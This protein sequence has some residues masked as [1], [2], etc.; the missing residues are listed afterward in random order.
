MSKRSLFFKMSTGLLFFYSLLV[1]VDVFAATVDVSG[2]GSALRDAVNAANPGDTVRV[3]DSMDYECFNLPKAL[4]IEA[5]SGQTPRVIAGSGAAT[6][7]GEAIRV[8]DDGRGATLKGLHLIR[9]ENT[10]TQPGNQVI[11]V[12]NHSSDVTFTM[13]DC[14][15]E[16]AVPG[17][18][19]DNRVSGF[20]DKVVFNRCTFRRSDSNGNPL[21]MLFDGGNNAT[22]NQCTFGPGSNG[23]SGVTAIPEANGTITFDNCLFTGLKGGGRGI[24]ATDRPQTYNINGCTF[25]TGVFAIFAGNGSSSPGTVFNIHNSIFGAMN[26]DWQIFAGDGDGITFNMT[27]T[28]FFANT[29]NNLS[30]LGNKS[31]TFNLKHCTFAQ[32]PGASPDPQQIWFFMEGANSTASN[33]SVQNCIVSN[34]AS[35]V[36]A[37]L[38]FNNP[39]NPLAIPP[40][41]TAGKTLWNV[42]GGN[43]SGVRPGDVVVG[44]GTDLF[45]DPLFAGDGYHLGAGSAALDAGVDVGVTTD[46]DGEA[47]PQGGSVPDMGADE[48]GLS[49]GCVIYVSGGGSALGDAV[50]DPGTGSNCVIII[51]DSLEYN[52][53]NLNKPITIQAAVGQTPTVIAGLGGATAGGEAIRVYDDGRGAT[54][55]GLH[56]I[57]NENTSTQPG[58]QVIAVFNHSSDVTFTMEDCIVEIAVP[59]E[60]V[61]NRVSGFG[62]KVVFNRCTFRRSDSNGNPLVM[63]FDGGNNAT[64]NNCTFGPGSNGASG[65]T[66]IPEANGTITFNDCLFTGLKGGGR[67]ITAT[68]RPQTYNINDCTFAPGVFALF[69]GN[70]ASSPGT[71]FNIQRTVFSANNTDWQIFAGDGSGITFNLTNNVFFVDS[72]PHV[73]F[74]GS[75]GQNWNVKHCTF[76]QAPGSSSPSSVVWFFLEG[77]DPSFSTIDVRNCVVSCPDAINGVSLFYNNPSQPLIQEPVVT[78]GTTL[79]ETYNVDPAKVLS[80]DLIVGVGTNIFGH[81]FLDTDGYHL[82]AG[83]EALA[84]GENVGVTQDIDGESRPLGGGSPDLGADESAIP[85]GAAPTVTPTPENNPTPT[86]TPT[87][88]PTQTPVPS[89]CN[90]SVSGGGFALLEAVAAAE[91]GCVLTIEDSLDYVSFNLDKEITIQ[92]APGQTPRIVAGTGGASGGEAIR[93]YD[94]GRRAILKRLHLVRVDDLN[95]NGGSQVLVVFQNSDPSVFYMFD[96]TIEIDAPGQSLDNRVCFIG[97]TASIHN[98]TFRR[99]DDNPNP[100]L[101]IGDAAIDSYIEGCTFGPAPDGTGVVCTLN[102]PKRSLTFSHCTFIENTTLKGNLGLGCFDR[103]HLMNVLDCDFGGNS[104]IFGGNNSSAPGTVWNIQRCIF[105]PREEGGARVLWAADGD[106]AEYNYTNCVF[107]AGNQNE[108]Q[109]NGEGHANT[110]RFTHCTFTDAPGKQAPNFIQWLFLG[111][112]FSDNIDLGTYVF[113]N[114]IIS[115][116]NTSDVLVMGTRGLYGYVTVEAGV[117]LFNVLSSNPDDSLRGV[118]GATEIEADPLLAADRFHLTSG[119]PAEGVG[120]D[121][122]ITEDFDNQMRPQGGSNPDLGADEIGGTAVELWTQY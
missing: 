120:L 45:G 113:H 41:V 13:E 34:P 85:P 93:V 89:G 62:D 70:N 18:S 27:N 77:E 66:S 40:V 23:A 115:H 31:H 94:A 119:S 109:M 53:F 52:A 22:F 57:R 61:D 84:A 3:N 83:S 8:Y 122:G 117:N 1:C 46:I 68:D 39:G 75:R 97:D 80:G 26:T 110:F 43:A 25:N 71:V 56:L 33:I 48:S 76:A 73:S 87:P 50:A 16:I 111:Q 47:R 78:A 54:L 5:V 29:R 17:E 100:R 114:N 11:A 107:F 55:K 74:S 72:R 10:S 51:Q 104:G 21:V 20:G 35:S 12:F 15:V 82:K 116:P 6:A 44:V 24:T 38:F 121:K 32:A 86:R 99:N 9:N 19:V 49:G 42:T 2:G 67:G 37:S 7:G 101:W 28:V 95:L 103:P 69:A 4:I 88:T 14:I 63:L 58:N 105:G 96:C 81:A 106:G 65:V 91:T 79:W 112:D 59:G 36:G 64:F 92:A 30:F 102:T 60:S 108:R 98:C 90:V 118:E